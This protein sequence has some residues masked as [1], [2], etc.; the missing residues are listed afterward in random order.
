MGQLLLCKPHRQ[1]DYNPEDPFI[2]R[3]VGTSKSQFTGMLMS[4]SL[5]TPYQEGS[6]VWKKRD[7]EAAVKFEQVLAFLQWKI[8]DRMPAELIKQ[9]RALY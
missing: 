8:T 9:I 7:C 2:Y 3:V 6:Y 4:G 1:A 5:G